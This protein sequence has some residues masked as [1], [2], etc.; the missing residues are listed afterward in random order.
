M[1]K[2]FHFLLV[3]LTMSFLIAEESEA[4]N[5][6]IDVTFIMDANDGT[7]STSYACMDMDGND[8]VENCMLSANFSLPS[9][10]GVS[11]DHPH[12]WQ[13][14]LYSEGVVIQHGDL[15][16]LTLNDVNLTFSWV[17]EGCTTFECQNTTIHQNTH[18]GAYYLRPSDCVW[19]QNP[20][21]SQFKDG[22]DNNNTWRCFNEVGDY[23]SGL[24][25]FHV[26]EEPT[27]CEIWEQDN[28]YL[29]DRSKP[30]GEMD[31]DCPCYGTDE[32]C[33]DEASGL[34]IGEDSG[35]GDGG[36]TI[37]VSVERLK[38][39]EHPAWEWKHK[40]LTK[41]DDLQMDMNYTA[42]VFISEYYDSNGDGNDAWGGLDWWWDIDWEGGYDEDNDGYHNQSENP[43]SLMRGCYNINTSLYESDDIHSDVSNATVLVF[44][45]LDFA[46][47]TGSCV[48]GVY[49]E[50]DETTNNQTANNE[51]A[52]NETKDD[53]GFCPTEITDENKDD[54]DDACIATFDDPEDSNLT[55][56]E[57]LPSLSFFTSIYT[58]AIIAFR[59]R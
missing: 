9:E 52:N 7:D 21:V 4:E 14:V 15:A 12:F 29:V 24:M 30:E 26:T 18:R 19:F 55:E 37:T 25:I 58:I 54:V 49:S 35:T 59:R 20:G 3:F 43:V 40:Y 56:E 39:P 2:Y 1:S 13:W 47:G 46:V 31:N 22:F 11:W 38:I 42:V 27:V 23:P 36:E 41:V 44:A 10:G 6:I 48:D 53:S 28:P 34:F 45:D 32:G 17:A 57:L 16:E 8:S 33:D 50:V 5:E 51:T